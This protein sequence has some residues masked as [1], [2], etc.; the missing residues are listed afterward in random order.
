MSSERDASS[1]VNADEML[2]A[3]TAA[4]AMASTFSDVTTAARKPA[5]GSATSLKAPAWPSRIGL[6]LA[7]GAVLLIPW[8][9]WLAVRLP[10]R[11][12]SAHWDVAWVGFDIV[13]TALVAATAIAL[14]K[15]S[16]LA[17]FTATA[18]ATMLL[19][20]AWFDIFTAR[21]GDELDWAIIVAALVELPLA[22]LCFWLVARWATRREPYSGV[23]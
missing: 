11:H 14:W 17:P 19:I 15:R 20:D 8:T 2:T 13:L 23:T 3:P 9:A 12:V 21:S 6:L 22:V 18:A 1:G 4:V 16:P 10:S 7:V 5:K